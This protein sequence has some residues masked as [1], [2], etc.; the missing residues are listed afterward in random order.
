MNKNINKKNNN[1]ELN[2]APTCSSDIVALPHTLV[3]TSP[4]RPQSYQS[5]GR[6]A[7]IH[8]PDSSLVP[9]SCSSRPPS[10]TILKI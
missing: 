8:G 5:T 2:P 7:G 10:H 6:P 3:G 4:G 9:P 1:R